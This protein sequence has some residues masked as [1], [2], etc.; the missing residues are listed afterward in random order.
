[1]RMGKLFRDGVLTFAEPRLDRTRP[2]S[3]ASVSEALTHAGTYSSMELQ[4]K[5]TLGLFGE[6]AVSGILSGVAMTGDWTASD[7]TS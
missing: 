2:I 4:L 5:Q 1:M 6:V 3:L 7:P